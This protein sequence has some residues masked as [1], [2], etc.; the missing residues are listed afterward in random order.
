MNK[1]TQWVNIGIGVF[2]IL[3]GAIILILSLATKV[4]YTKIKDQTLAGAAATLIDPETLLLNA[5]CTWDET[6]IVL[7][8]SGGFV[9]WA[10]TKQY[11]DV[12]GDPLYTY[13]LL[14]S[15]GTVEV[16]KSNKNTTSIRLNGTAYLTNQRAPTQKW[17]SFPRYESDETVIIVSSCPN[18]ASS[19]PN[20]MSVWHYSDDADISIVGRNF[21]LSV[22]FSTAS[23]LLDGSGVIN[24]VV[25]ATDATTH[26]TGNVVVY[27]STNTFYNGTASSTATVTSGSF[28]SAKINANQPK[29]EI[30][31]HLVKRFINQTYSGT[32]HAIYV[33]GR[34]F[35][36]DE[37]LATSI[38]LKHKY[39]G[40][41][42]SY[43]TTI[44]CAVNSQITI[45]NTLVSG[46]TPITLYQ[47]SPSL[48]A[49]LTFSTST[50]ALTGTPTTVTPS[51]RFQI[52]ATNAFDELDYVVMLQV[53]ESQTS[54]IATVPP[55]ISFATTSI[56]FRLNE[57]IVSPTPVN[58]GGEIVSYSISPQISSGMHFD[59][60]KG[61]LTGSASENLITEYTVTAQNDAGKSS[62]KFRLQVGISILYSSDISGTVGT[63]IQTL[64]PTVSG[65]SDTRLDYSCTGDLYGLIFDKS[66]GS[67]SGT[68]TSVGTNRI[69]VSLNTT[70]T[71][72][73]STRIAISII[74][75]G[76]QT[77]FKDK[78]YYLSAG[79]AAVGV[80]AAVLGVTLWNSKTG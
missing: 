18:Q 26:T 80:G 25:L 50:G 64:T 32:I 49:G 54:R 67:I 14:P 5:D 42:L 48:P 60:Q 35:S 79:G 47:I 41:Y 36:S 55:N 39:L 30:G 69:T 74:K 31:R 68:P 34:K 71:S 22:D 52:H 4:F 1:M 46:A 40:P 61:I 45:E 17:S 20:G 65:T 24:P 19:T 77:V 27:P 72:A 28:I 13:D 56:T 21:D 12:D 33:F 23:S 57:A 62:G 58:T 29:L 63:A 76:S 66:T 16:C 8:S 44:I 75:T 9:K 7:N 11:R 73:V 10:S 51:S 37:V 43:P 3:I 70:S 2:L 59:T 53:A 38:Y 6:S 15:T 78:V